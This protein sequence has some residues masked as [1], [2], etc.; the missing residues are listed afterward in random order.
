MLATRRVLQ[1]WKLKDGIYAEQLVDSVTNQM[2]LGPA[3]QQRR[4]RLTNVK[5][6]NSILRSAPY[7]LC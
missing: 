2:Q 6:H 3:G 1:E 5:S 7:G 4:R